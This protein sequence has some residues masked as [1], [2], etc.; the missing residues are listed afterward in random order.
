MKNVIVFIILVCF[1]N[2]AFA[3]GL[4][5]HRIT[6]QIAESYFHK[7]IKEK[8]KKILKNE[9]M[10]MASNWPDFIKSDPK[11]RKKYSAW[12]YVS[13]PPKVKIEN[14]KGKQGGDILYGIKYFSDILKDK[15]A[16]MEEKRDALAFIIHLI[17]DLHQPLHVG[18]TNDKGGN[19]KKV[20]WFGESTNLHTVWDERLIQMQELSF[21]EYTKEINKISGEDIKKL[22]SSTVLDWAKE[23]R[24]YLPKAYGFKQTRYWE[25][26]YNYKH[27]KYLNQ[28]L[29][30]GGV[31]LAGLLN[32]V[33]K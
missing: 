8:V 11:L 15:E 10:A 32:K 18:Y 30:S 21:T 16:G 33:L 25:Y 6:A 7:N 22:Q 24:R 17:G 19:L 31:R 20:N 2:S 4:L 9:T 27:I 28:R 12:H 5:G 1:Q 3:W 14:R 13:F 23:S 29:L 26:R